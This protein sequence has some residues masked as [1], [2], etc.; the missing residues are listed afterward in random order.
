MKNIACMFY[1]KIQ[2]KDG[3]FL[4]APRRVLV[5]CP[6]WAIHSTLALRILHAWARDHP[7]PQ[8]GTP[9]AVAIFIPLAELKGSLSNYVAKELLPKGP[10]N[11]FAGGFGGFNS[12]W[13]SLS[14]LKAKLLFVLDGYD[15][16]RGSPKRKGKNLP[17]DV[18]D[19]LEGRLFPDARIVVLS[20]ATNCSDLLPMMQR[21]VTYEGLTWGRSASLLG[22]G[23]WGAPTRLLD[24]VQQYP[25]LRSAVRTTLGCLAIA[26]IYESNGGDLPTEEIDVVESVI[27]CV[28][29]ESSANNAAELGRLA[30]FSLKTHRSS[31]TTS[32]IRMYCSSPDS[33]I[34]GCLEK[35]PLFGRTAKRK[36]ESQFM[37]VCAGVTEFLAASYLAS[38]ASRPGLLAAE[39]AGLSLGD[40]I[41]AEMLKILTF[42]MSLLGSR[43][44]ILLSKLTPL[45]L[46]PQTIFS[47]AIAG[48]ESD[49]NLNA[50]CDLLGISKS[51]PVSPLE[52]RPIWVQI[53]STPTELRGWGMALKSPSCTLR[54]LELAYQMEKNTIHDSR[55]GMD[56]FLDALVCNDSVT[57]LR[58]SSL[59]EI[60]AKETEIG[61]LANCVAKAL[62]KPKLESFE[63]ILTL[64]EEDPPVLKLQAVVSALCRSIPRQP[65]LSSLLLD[66][67]LCT[68]QLVQLCSIL[69]KCPQITRVSLPHLRCERGAVGA[70]AALLTNRPITSLALPSCWG[71]RDDPP[72]SSGVS[73]GSG[74]GSSTGTSGLIKQ[75]S[76]TGAPSPRS[77]P[78]GL[79]SSLPRGVLPPPSSM[80][81][82]ATLPRQPIECPPDKRSS[83]SVVSSKPWY[84]TPACEGGPHNSGTLH[85][86]F[87]TIR[88]PYSRLNGLDLSKAQLSLEDAMCLGETVR[89]STTLHSIKIEGAS[90]LSEIL[91]SV[92]G[93]SE[94]PC[95]QMM[96]IGSPRLALED[97][98]IAMSA[99]ALANCST[100][101][102]LSIEGWSFRIESATSLSALRAFLS[103]TSIRELGLSNCRL[104]L[105]IFKSDSIPLSNYE[106]RSV[107]VIKISGAQV[108]LGDHTIL[109]G[110]QLL[111]Y[112]GGFPCLRELD[113]SAPARSGLGGTTSPPLIMDDKCVI[114]FFQCLHLQFR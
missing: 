36:G 48:G 90:R 16:P 88:E 24:T 75:S 62:T 76:L 109:R 78:P 106:C 51:P 52:M 29:S 30:L 23:Q 114:T 69:E 39:I 3:P 6:T 113:L 66:L 18:I 34:L 58:I 49:T 107:V 46:S 87:L 7:W 47:L 50:L 57:T 89:L 103:F 59:I 61:Y 15:T 27:N 37:A 38:L 14:S 40:E 55:N 83:D 64:L 17:A 82:S 110:P 70:L 5:E 99:R 4:E 96:S 79:F 81:R 13:N 92:L 31:V 72:S 28:G 67:G 93:A 44:H 100:L 60:D 33:T 71:A 10:S 65:K 20:V 1:L 101:K 80:G 63:L 84:P 8:R 32:E 26:S 91:P 11:P 42:S 22:G 77:Y 102:L 53:R 56:H 54:N 98:A 68:S 21:H 35:A 25:A 73:M 2:T 95:L 97:G 43:A 19:L 104:H 105:P 74:S 9:V 86:L 12:A 108:I 41:D 45:W 111:P 112:I 94:S 85:D